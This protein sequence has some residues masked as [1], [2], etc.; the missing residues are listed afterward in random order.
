MEN[1][2]E[3]YKNTENVMAQYRRHEVLTFG[4][5]FVHDNVQL[6]ITCIITVLGTLLVILEKF[7]HSLYSPDLDVRLDWFVFAL[8]KFLTGQSESNDGI[9]GNV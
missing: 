7:R 8:T 9:K 6:R 1:C 2:A 3:S 5:V 4:M